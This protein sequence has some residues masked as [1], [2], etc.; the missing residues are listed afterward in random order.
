MSEDRQRPVVVTSIAWLLVV[1]GLLGIAGVV[2]LYA[3]GPKDPARSG[4]PL[5]LLLGI[6]ALAFVGPGMG[7]ALLKGRAWAWHTALFFFVAVAGAGYAAIPPL[8]HAL[9]L[10]QA[11][12]ELTRVLTLTKIVVSAALALLLLTGPVVDFFGIERRRRWTPLVIDIVLAAGLFF[13]VSWVVE[14]LAAGP[15]DDV[16]QRLTML[17]ERRANAEEDVAFMLDELDDGSKEERVTAAWALGRSGR[18]DVIEPLLRACRE[19]RDVSVKINAIGAVAELGGAEIE[20]DLVGFLNEDEQEVRLAA[21]RGL[22]DPR[23]VGALDV[24]GRVLLE[25]EALRSTAIDALGNM[26]SP[27][28]LTYLRQV[29]KDQD[30]DVR[31]RAAYWLGKLGDAASVPTLIEM[32]HDA[33]WSVRA[34]AAQSLGMLGD[35]AARGALEALAD[36]PNDQVRGAAESALLRLP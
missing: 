20:A 23:F 2:F 16:V 6:G 30:E 32:L 19:D 4:L 29:T 8:I 27:A 21:L 25:D 24:V 15:G 18:G 13:G 7:N 22:A 12:V 11:I 17:G 36:D 3:S 14:R 10:P 26:G 31:T 5:E 28:A 33:S 35:P 1:G 9:G 34:N